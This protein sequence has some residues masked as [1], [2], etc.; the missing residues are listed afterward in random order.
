[1][2]TYFRVECRAEDSAAPGEYEFEIT[3]SSVLAGREKEKVPY[4]I[5]PVLSKIVV[6]AGDDTASVIPIER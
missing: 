1:M 6:S 5:A 2:K 4:S 3:S